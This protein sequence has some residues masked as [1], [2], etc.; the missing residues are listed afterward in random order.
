MRA[1]R[2]GRRRRDEAEDRETRAATGI[3][4]AR[5]A[6]VFVAPSLALPEGVPPEAVRGAQEAQELLRLQGRVHAASSLLRRSLHR[7]RGPQLRQAIPDRAPRGPGRPGDRGS[8]QDRISDGAQ[9]AAGGRP[10]HRHHP[11]PPRR[12]GPLLARAGLRGVEGSPARARAR[13]APLTE[14]RDLRPLRRA[15]LP[16]A[17]HPGQQRLPDRASASR[18]LRPPAGAG[19]APGRRLRPE[20]SRAS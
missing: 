11:L 15:L 1:L 19:V 6:A 5:E 4:V 16:A 7:L 8:G 3:R 14:R 10:G 13:P 2:R 18:L 17:R 20:V 9:D 12:R